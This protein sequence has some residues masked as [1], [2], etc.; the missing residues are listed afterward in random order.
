MKLAVLIAPFATATAEETQAMRL[1]QANLLE[2]GV[3]AIWPPDVM[4][5]LLDDDDPEERH[6]GLLASQAI[7]RGVAQLGGE[8]HLIGERVTDGMKGDLVAWR[9]ATPRTATH[10]LE[11]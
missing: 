2:Q 7:V 4:S 9:R 8:A 11:R 3:V 5:P 6:I 1:V 10:H